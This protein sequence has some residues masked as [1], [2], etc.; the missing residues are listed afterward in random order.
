MIMRNS[1]FT[2][3]V[4][5]LAAVLWGSEYFSRTLWEPDEAR[6]VYVAREMRADSHWLVPHRSGEYYAHKP[7]L[8][9]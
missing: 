9:F 8:M 4:I 3:G 5:L 2:I 1:I 6:Y 7:P